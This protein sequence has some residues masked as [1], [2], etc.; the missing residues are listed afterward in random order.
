ME[1]HLSDSSQIR[2]EWLR[3]ESLYVS[4]LTP[5]NTR[6]SRHG[7]HGDTCPDRQA[8]HEFIEPL[9]LPPQQAA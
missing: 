6:E 7:D 5:T 8:L 2:F 4:F 9:Q 1:L 3:D